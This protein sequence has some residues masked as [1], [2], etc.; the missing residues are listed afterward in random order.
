MPLLRNF[1]LLGRV[2]NLPTV[3]SN[4]LAG[5]WLGGGGNFDQLPFLFSGVTLIYLGG[6]F[7]NDA[8]D[9]DF[10]RQHRRERPIPSGA[11]TAKSVWRWGLVLLGVGAACLYWLGTVAGW[12]GFALV[13]CVLV[14]DAIHKLITFSPVLMGI[15]RFFVYVIAA[16]VG[17]SGVTGWAIWCG[18]ALGAYVTGL[19]FVARRE[20]ARGPMQYW[21]LILLAVPI[22]LALIMN[23]GPFRPPA[24]LLAAIFGLWVLRCL[25]HT[26][27]SPVR[28][29]GR[30][31]SGLLAGIVLVDWLAIADAPLELS[32]VFLGLFL[33][34]L[35][36]QRFVPAT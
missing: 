33:A 16:A 1:L 27:W 7:L 9:E 5:W 23:A 18:L 34:A 28:R 35:L 32:F 29:V 19:S 11:A 15:C 25:R 17:V 21:P 12:L 8:F 4:C 26:L 6:M 22:L 24:L 20:S 2:S 3:W 30:T 31:V 36:L 10:D 14:Y 13:V